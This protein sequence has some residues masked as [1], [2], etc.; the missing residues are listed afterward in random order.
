MNKL[1]I[2]LV[3]FTLHSSLSFSQAECNL[4]LFSEEEAMKL[5]AYGKDLEKR[6]L[7]KNPADTALIAQLKGDYSKDLCGYS[8][9][10]VIAISNYLKELE[11]KDSINNVPPVVVV[12]TVVETPVTPVDTVKAIDPKAAAAAKVERTLL[13]G[14]NS[15]TLKV[16]KLDD[17]VAQLKADK[18]IAIVL[19]GYADADGSD[20]YNIALS[21]RRAKSVKDYLVSKGIAAARITTNGH[22]EQNP[23]GANDTA[24][25]KAQNRRVTVSIK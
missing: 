18:T 25:G 17:L 2:L 23:I 13:F 16:A 5:S 8:D 9:S 19:D 14:T 7:E 1:Y 4:N 15:A 3:G 21:K 12:E 22:G 20:E 10:S 11:K 6:I 24:E